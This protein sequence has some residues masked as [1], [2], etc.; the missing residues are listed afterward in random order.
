MVI[1]LGIGASII[2][3]IIVTDDLWPRQTLGHHVR[4]QCI[5]A[6]DFARDL[7]TF[8]RHLAIMRIAPVIRIDQRCSCRI[9]GCQPHGSTRTRMQIGGVERYTGIFEL[10]NTCLDARTKPQM[11]LGIR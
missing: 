5:L 1:G 10:L 11:K 6:H 8:K 2:E 9:A 3:Q 7:Q 4:F